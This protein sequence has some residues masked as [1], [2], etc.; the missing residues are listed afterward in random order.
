MNICRFKGKR[1]RCHA[2]ARTTQINRGGAAGFYDK[3]L[4][5]ISRVENQSEPGHDRALFM[6]I[7]GG[8]AARDGK[9]STVRTPP[10][11]T[12]PGQP[13]PKLPPDYVNWPEIANRFTDKLNQE[14]KLPPSVLRPFDT[15]L[16]DYLGFAEGVLVYGRQPDSGVKPTDESVAITMARAFRDTGLHIARGGGVV[17][18]TQISFEP[19]QNINR[20]ICA[21]QVTNEKAVCP[22]P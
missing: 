5:I 18:E 11:K 19:Y 3:A 4:N 2:T 14:Q 10:G 17:K 20:G 21:A 8:L 13:P 9:V 15:R 12:S 1:D 22:R 6:A 7:V 16:A